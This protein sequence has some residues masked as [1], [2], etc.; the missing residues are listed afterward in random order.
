MLIRSRWGLWFIHDEA[1]LESFLLSHGDV[2][3]STVMEPSSESLQFNYDDTKFKSLLL[4]HT[5]ISDSTMMKLSQKVF[6]L[7]TATSSIWPQQ[8]ELENLLLGRSNVSDSAMMEVSP[9]A[10]NS[11]MTIPSQKVFYS[12]EVISPIRPWKTS[13]KIFYSAATASPIR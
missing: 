3:N 5:D 11:A 4:G 9:T 6:Y 2:S 8:T 7:A 10:F 13:W 1:K 12:A